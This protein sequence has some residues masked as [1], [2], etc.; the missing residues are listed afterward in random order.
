MHRKPKP[1]APEPRP[2][3]VWE[4]IEWAKHRHGVLVSL[5]TSTSMHGGTDVRIWIRN[6]GETHYNHWTTKSQWGVTP[7][8]LNQWCVAVEALSMEWKEGIRES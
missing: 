4:F 7:G 1:P 6:H 5:E 3:D 2:K 8:I